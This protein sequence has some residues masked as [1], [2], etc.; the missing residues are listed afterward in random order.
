MIANKCFEN[1]AKFKYMGMRVTNQNCIHK[2]I[3]SRLKLGNACYYSV[4]NLL[5]YCLLSKSLKTKIHKTT[6]LHI[7]LYGYETWSLILREEQIQ[8]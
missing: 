8:C 3:K 7:V 4:H 1:V 5:A 2:E 6:I